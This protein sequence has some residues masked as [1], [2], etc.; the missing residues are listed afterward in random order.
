[1]R[2]PAFLALQLHRVKQNRVNLRGGDRSDG[3]MGRLTEERDL[4]QGRATRGKVGSGFNHL[5]YLFTD[6]LHS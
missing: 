1:M 3:E 4:R 6:T 2:V 5:E